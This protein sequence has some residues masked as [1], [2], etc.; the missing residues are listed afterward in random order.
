VWRHDTA[1]ALNGYVGVLPDNP[2]FHCDYDELDVEVH[3]GLT[4]AGHISYMDAN[5]WWFGFDTQHAW[6]F[7]P[8]LE[9][10]LTEAVAKMDPQPTEF[11]LGQQP[12][13]HYRDLEFVT[14]EVE[15]LYVQLRELA[16]AIARGERDIPSSVEPE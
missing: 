9:K 15:G 2:L 13:Q 4:F 11:T 3:G 8:L 5:V 6:D 16:E 14:M 10:R 1:G 7:A 12:W